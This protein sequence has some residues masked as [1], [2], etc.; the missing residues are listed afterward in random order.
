MARI[1][2]KQIVDKART[3]EGKAHK[4]LTNTSGEIA[5]VWLLCKPMTVAEHMV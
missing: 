5:E 2:H 1:C 3:S 4:M